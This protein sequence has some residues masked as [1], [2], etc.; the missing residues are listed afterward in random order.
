MDNTTYILDTSSLG[1]VLTALVQLDG[2]SSTFVAD[3][4]NVLPAHTPNSGAEGF[5]SC[6]FGGEPSRQIWGAAPAISDLARCE[7]AVQETL[8]VSLQYLP[9]AVDLDDVNAGGKHQLGL[10]PSHR[11]VICVRG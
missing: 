11:L 2:G 5:H 3:D 8:A 7:D 4:F 1:S 6:F 9:H 10:T